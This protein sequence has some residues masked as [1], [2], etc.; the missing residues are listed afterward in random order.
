LTASQPTVGVQEPKAVSRAPEDDSIP[1][2]VAILAGAL[3]AA[4]GAAVAAVGRLR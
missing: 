4:G 1:T 3:V 2:A